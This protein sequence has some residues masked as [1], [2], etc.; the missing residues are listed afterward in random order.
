[1]FGEDASKG[2]IDR[3]EYVLLPERFA[4]CAGRYYCFE[5]AQHAILNM[6]DPEDPAQNTYEH[7]KI[8]YSE[9]HQGSP[10][11]KGPDLH[12][13]RRFLYKKR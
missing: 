2:P 13:G 11:K 8:F 5:A 3:P 4:D 10:R 6:K 9:I 7:E 1:M 12:L